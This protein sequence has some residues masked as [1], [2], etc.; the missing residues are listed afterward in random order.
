MKDAA[1]RLLPDLGPDSEES[2]CRSS[3]IET[4]LARSMQKVPSPLR[5]PS[6]TGGWPQKRG[7][8]RVAPDPLSDVV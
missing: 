1:F 8:G 3:K 5:Q 2:Y 4:P 7:A 6:P